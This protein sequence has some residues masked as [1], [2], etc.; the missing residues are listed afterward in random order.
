MGKDGE[1]SPMIDVLVETRLCDTSGYER[2]AQEFGHE[3]STSLSTS[4]TVQ[5]IT[6]SRLPDLDA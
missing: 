4:I 5:V 2:K 6:T 1:A 3:A